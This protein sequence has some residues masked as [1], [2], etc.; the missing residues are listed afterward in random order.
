MGLFYGMNTSKSYQAEWWAPEGSRCFSGERYPG[1]LTYNREENSTLEI[2]HS[3]AGGVFFRFYEKYDVIWGKSANGLCFSLFN[4]VLVRQQDFSKSEFVV[5]YILV[6]QHVLSLDECRFDLCVAS[7]PH[8]RDWAYCSRIIDEDREDNV[9]VWNLDM[10][11][12]DPIVSVE[13]EKGVQTYLWPTLSYHV[14]RFLRTVEQTTTYNIEI[15]E[16]GSIRRYLSLVSEFSEFL[17]IALFAQQRP[18]EIKFRNKQDGLYYQFLYKVR[19]STNPRGLCL[20]DYTGVSEKVSSMLTVWHSRYEQVSPIANYLIRSLKNDSP[21]D[22]PGFLILAH[23]LDGYFKRFVNKLDGRD[24][25]QYKHGIDKLLRRYE[26]IEAIQKCK[27]DSEV[28]RDSRDKYSHLLPDDVINKAVSGED[29][30][31]LTEKCKVLLTCCILEMLGL[32]KNEIN[33]CCNSSPIRMI[34]NSLPIE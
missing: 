15:R 28:L 25:Q 1:M 21:F 34:V 24:T 13:I 4:V 6:G 19:P 12:R 27:I 33:D 11:K 18:N 20:I 22:A 14:S 30:Y 3:S 16:K 10:R 9:L 2:I 26:D 17:S 8:L 23:A 5:N 32:D 29:L 31:W 7:F